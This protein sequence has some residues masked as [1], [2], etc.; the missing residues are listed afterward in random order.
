MEKRWKE[1][2][3]KRVYYA[4]PCVS[5]NFHCWHVEPLRSSCRHLTAKKRPLCKH[6][7]LPPIFYPIHVLW[8]SRSKMAL[9]QSN[10]S[11]I[12]ID[13]HNGLTWYPTGIPRKPSD[14]T[15]LQV[16]STVDVF[17]CV[18]QKIQLVIISKIWILTG[19]IAV[20]TYMER[21]ATFPNNISSFQMRK[22][23]VKNLSFLLSS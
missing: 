22:A 4:F 19:L 2:S 14:G 12:T 21:S 9:A 23:V 8:Q 20:E 13:T 10:G 7:N 11:R 3:K 5:Y 15:G 1:T 16:T 18:W 6:E 17:T